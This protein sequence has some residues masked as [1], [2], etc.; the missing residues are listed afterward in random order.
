MK[1]LQL[2]WWIVQAVVAVVAA[3]LVCC[4]DAQDPAQQLWRLPAQWIG[5]VYGL[6]R[7][8]FLLVALV[9]IIDLKV[10]IAEAKRLRADIRSQRLRKAR[11]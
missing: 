3:S 11:S 6:H 1:Y 9:T 10:K 5:V 8:F 2:I 7:G 4:L